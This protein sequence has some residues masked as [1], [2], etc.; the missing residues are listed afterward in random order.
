[1][2]SSAAAVITALGFGSTPPAIKTLPFLSNVALNPPNRAWAS[3]RGG[4]Q[5][6]V[7]ES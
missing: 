1:M 2:Y 6:R 5:L 3:G 7:S 4:D